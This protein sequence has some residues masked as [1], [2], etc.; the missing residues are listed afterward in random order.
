VG[1]WRTAA[2]CPLSRY[3]QPA[4]GLEDHR[5]FRAGFRRPGSGAVRAAC[6]TPRHTITVMQPLQHH[7]TGRHRP[8]SA[9]ALT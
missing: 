3:I 8:R 7:G 2:H 4:V 1:E 5:L 6:V 9:E